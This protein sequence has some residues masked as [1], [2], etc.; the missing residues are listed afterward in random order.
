MMISRRQAFALALAL[1]SALPMATP[2]ADDDAS[3]GQR[4]ALALLEKAAR[5]QS[6]ERWERP[7][8]SLHGSFFGTIRT[9]D[10]TGSVAVERW[11]TRDPERIVTRHTESVT[12][13]RHTIG[14]D[15]ETAWFRN[16][17]TGEVVIYSDDTERFGV[18]IDLLEEQRRLTRMLMDSVVL[19]A[20]LPRLERIRL[21]R[22]GV[23]LDIEGNGHAVR[24]VSAEA[25]DDLYPPAADAPPPT[26]DDPPPML[27]LVLALDDETGKLWSLSVQPRGRGAVAPLELHFDYHE[28]TPSGLLVPA[29]VRVFAGNN[30]AEAIRL[31]V[32]FDDDDQLDFDLDVTVDPAVFSP[33]AKES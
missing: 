8:R 24:Y 30:T 14:H 16:D 12:G 3:K 15:G 27:L 2:V 5:Y 17:A 31:G 29:N 25:I 22:R 6:R 4:D 33:P 26:P 18:D 23:H 19:D 32:S 9:P 13:S 7:P 1:L 21:G 11:Y 10:A 28:R 20:L